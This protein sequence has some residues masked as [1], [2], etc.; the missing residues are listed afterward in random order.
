MNNEHILGWLEEEENLLHDD[1][2]DL[3]ATTEID[4]Q[5]TN[6]EQLDFE[7][8]PNEVTESAGPCEPSVTTPT[9]SRPNLSLVSNLQP[10]YVGRDQITGWNVHEPPS[11]RTPRQNIITTLPGVKAMA[12]HSNTIYDTWKLFFPDTLIDE[13]VRCTNEQLLVMS[14]KYTRGEKDC[15]QTDFCELHAFF[16]ILYLAGVKKGNHLNIDELWANDG[17]APDFFV[18]TM[19]K[20]RFQTLIQA[21]RFDKKSTRPI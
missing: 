21:I 4:D 8:E 2:S 12:R 10:Y 16:G 3:D 5:D 18:A 20:K 19:S 9:V 7:N 11:S 15:P 14:Q 6:S 1:V 17:T 13:I